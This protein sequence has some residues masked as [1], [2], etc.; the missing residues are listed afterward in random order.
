MWLDFTDW[1]LNCNELENVLKE[2]SVVFSSG[3]D[4]GGNYNDGFMRM[5]IATTYD[6]VQGCLNALEKCYLEKVAK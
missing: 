2:Y 6:R 4:F 1:G 5:N 3:Y